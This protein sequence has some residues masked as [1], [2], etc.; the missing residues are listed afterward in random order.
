MH[1]S[2]LSRVSFAQSFLLVC[3]SA[4]PNT[5]SAPVSDLFVYATMVNN[6]QSFPITP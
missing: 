3:S 2:P 1:L 6:L 4:M 5:D